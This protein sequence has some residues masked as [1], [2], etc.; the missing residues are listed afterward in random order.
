MLINGRVT[1][2]FVHFSRVK[3]SLTDNS[4]AQLRHPTWPEP[5]VSYANKE[6][7]VGARIYIKVTDSSHPRA[8]CLS[9]SAQ[10]ANFIEADFVFF[11]VIKPCHKFRMYPGRASMTRNSILMKLPNFP[12]P[13][14]S[15]PRKLTLKTNPPL[16]LPL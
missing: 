7:P 5:G 6:A 2:S 14:S 9:G 12:V 11:G 4:L 13:K 8:F 3:I 1:G 10:R 16:I 15:S